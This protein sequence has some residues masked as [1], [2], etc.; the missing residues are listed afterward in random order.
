MRKLLFAALL[1]LTIGIVPIF[2]Q[3]ATPE[4]DATTAP[5][6]SP[7]SEETVLEMVERAEDALER[8]QSAT[9]MAFN[10]LGLFEALSLVVTIG[11]GVL[12][13]VGFTNFNRARVQL[14]ETRTNVITQIQEYQDNFDAQIAAREAELKA[15]RD[16]LEE[17]AMQERQQ[18]SNALLANAL[19]P[20]GERQYKFS[21]Y[22]G[23]LSTY[24]RA[25]ELDPGNPVVHQKFAYVR[26]KQGNIDDAKHH[27]EKA[28][29]LTPDFAPALAGLGFVYRRLGEQVQ[30][31]EDLSGEERRER[32]TT[33]TNFYNK[34]EGLLNKAL[35]LSPK[36][37]DDDGESWWGI[38]G[39]LY[40]RRNQTELALNAY[41]EAT[42]VTPQSSYGFVNLALL[43]LKQKDREKMQEYYETVERIAR[44]EAE[45]EQGNFW[46]YA[47][48]IVSSYAVGKIEQADEALPIAIAI[49]PIDS[50][51]MLEGLVDTLADLKTVMEGEQAVAVTTAI[52]TLQQAIDERRRQLEAEKADDD[53]SDALENSD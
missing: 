51:Y 27:Y 21:D 9:D 48:L 45:G 25:L 36:L 6:N 44:K 41:Y 12:A 37:V 23:A 7:V 47:D 11:G 40:K 39:G 50:P 35:E 2:A 32:W 31:P 20:I 42:Q 26:E 17:G 52:Q 24:K 29:E 30:I 5:P 1:A 28:I 14:E 13:V 22:T 18:T 8:A 33:Q 15:L 53:A 49:A 43:Y 19:I 10:L 16:Q 34:A 46:G 3:E 4:V 38:L